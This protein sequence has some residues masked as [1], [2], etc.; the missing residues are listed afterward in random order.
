MFLKQEMDYRPDNG[1]LRKVTNVFSSKF[2]L[3]KTKISQKEVKERSVSL[4]DGHKKG[5][6]PKAN[7]ND[8]H[9]AT[10]N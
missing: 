8:Q 5:Q 1:L 9:E 4:A 3:I 7:D 10:E 6:S 2:N